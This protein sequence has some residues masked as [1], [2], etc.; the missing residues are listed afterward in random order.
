MDNQ[1]EGHPNNGT[2]GNPEKNLL[3]IYATTWMNLKMS[4]EKDVGHKRPHIV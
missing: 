4:Q 2:I 1:N 3:L